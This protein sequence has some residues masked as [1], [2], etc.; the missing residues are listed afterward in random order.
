MT[1]PHSERDTR[2]QIIDDRLRLA[3][4]NVDDPSQVIQELDI[5]VGGDRGALRER[6]GRHAG[7]RFVDYALQLRGRPA[8]VVEAKKTSRDAQ[9]G[10][11]QAMQYAEQLRHRDGGALPFILYTNGYD[12]YFWDSERYPPSKVTGFPTRDDLEW[13]A[14]RR[15]TRGPLSIELINPAIAGR[16][17]QIE[18]VRSL[19]DAIEVRRR[20][21]LM[22][23]AT[24]TGKT[25]TAAALVD[26]L[27]RAHWVKRVLFLVDRI[28]LQE[29]TVA[30]F[31]EHLA[32]SPLWPQQGETSFDRNRRIYVTTYPT[33]LNL[34][35]AG[36]TPAT[37]I[38]P[39]FFDLVIADES[40]R[41]IYNIY[42]QVVSYFHGL[43]L[44]LTATPRD[45][46]DHDTFALFDCESHDPT[47]AYGFDEAIAHDPPYLCNFEVLKV[48]TKF[49]VEGIR[50]PKLGEG[51][52]EQIE[53]EGLDPDTID[54]EGTDL[55]LKVA[56]S[57]TNAV[58]V[59]EFMEESIKDPGGVLPGKSIIFAV[60]KSHAWRLQDLFD[61]LYPEHRGRLARVLVSD[62]SRVHGKGGLLDQFKTR[63]MPRVAISVDMLDTGVDIREVVNLVFAKPVYSYVKFWQMI[64]RGTRVLEDDR[65]RRKPW[66]PEKD[67]F[68]VIDCWA[69]FEYFE[70]NPRGR[71]P[72]QQVP[73]PVRLFLA[74][75][76][77]LDAA[78]ARRATGVVERV[79]ADL[80]A[81]LDALPANNVVVLERQRDL[82]AARSDALWA[83]PDRDQLGFLRQT[84]APVLRAQSGADFKSLRFH[85]DVVELG[86]A[87]L[88]GNRDAADALRDIVIEQ[89]AEL[90]PGVNLVTRERELIE[91]AQTAEWWASVDQAKLRELMS[92]LAPLMRFRQE[93]RTAMLALN[94]ADLAAVRDRI[95]IGPDGRDMPISAYRRRVEETIRQ[96]VADNA[97][98]RRLQAGEHVSDQDLRDLADLL[99]KQ[100]PGIDEDRL[101]KVYDVRQAGFV[102]LIRHVL[103]V[104]PLERWS[105]FVTRAFEEF[106]GSHTT[107]SSLQIRF[108]QTLRTFV[109]HRGRVERG[110]LVDSPFTQLHPQGIRGVFQPRE[111]DEIVG[112][113]QGLVA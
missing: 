45:H 20:K 30:A 79:K 36:A 61:Q 111:I 10:Q 69:N 18:A 8:V 62:D 105:T 37:W 113:A 94:L 11:E 59:R 13:L 88:T 102:K 34:I 99:A 5:Y 2:Q 3:G 98:L 70:M 28:A 49:Q 87:L 25:R 84:I 64:G 71:E 4:W 86:T 109:L 29:Q 42:K 47:F 35:H 26:V 91:A 33:M 50:G 107:Y 32:S 60:S 43:T 57:G 112:F 38:S 83:R 51:E 85:I 95:A 48:R 93:R 52:R 54:F 12:T 44:G 27:Q 74:R 108:L 103:G 58:I 68:L 89:I 6:P 40:H 16:D 80:R 92:R 72:G 39:F 101:R 21:F 46:V 55:E 90:P 14:E 1:Q 73:M 100:D 104:E 65:T 67:R 22:V 41:S 9:L 31:K 97:V 96:L 7:H 56:N 78:L 75:L 17:Y 106:I 15:E 81:D 76:D 19:L 66:C 77:Q 110:D 23:M 82:A 24:G 53:F 63:D